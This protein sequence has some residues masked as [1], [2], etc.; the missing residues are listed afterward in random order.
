MN[1]LRGMSDPHHASVDDTGLEAGHGRLFTPRSAS[2]IEAGLIIATFEIAD[3]L[4]VYANAIG[5]V[6]ATEAIVLTQHG[7]SI[8]HVDWMTSLLCKSNK[9]MIHNT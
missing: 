4:R 6:A 7:D 9:I 8:E 1:V 2:A 3:R 5:Q